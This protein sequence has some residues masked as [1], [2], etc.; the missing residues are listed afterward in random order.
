MGSGYVTSPDALALGA[1]SAATPVEA[2]SRTV[3]IL[4]LGYVGLPTGIGLATGGV[5]VTG[6]DVSERRLQD[7]REGSVDLTAGERER[8]RSA[9]ELNE[10]VLTSNPGA[11]AAADAVLICVPTPVDES[12]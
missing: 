11:L 7:I 2:P 4:G 9:L 10:L 3:A 8:L 12:L 5:K 6:V 1:Q